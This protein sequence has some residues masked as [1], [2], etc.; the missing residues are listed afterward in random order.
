MRNPKDKP[1][2]RCY[3][4]FLAHHTAHV[5]RANVFNIRHSFLPSMLAFSDEKMIIQG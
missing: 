4:L 2:G 1:S 3:Y 5:P